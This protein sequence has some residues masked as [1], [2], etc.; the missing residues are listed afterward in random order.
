[1]RTGLGIL[2]W[3]VLAGAASAHEGH[4]RLPL[5][6]GKVSQTPQRGYV[7]ACP[8]RGGPGPGAFR[9][10]EWIGGGTWDPDAK[11]FVEGEVMWPNARI[12]VSVEEGKRVVRANNL[13][14][15]ATGEFPIRP[16]TRAYDYDRNPNHIGEQD[17][18]LS[19]PARPAAASQAGCVPMGMIGFALSGVAIF[20]AFD[21]AQRDA[22]AYEIQDRC[23]G[24]P[25]RTSQ[26]HYH[27]WSPCLAGARPDE[28]VGWML[29]GFPILGP[30]D[31]TGRELTD[32]DLDECHGRVG[33]VRIDGKVVTTFHYRFTREFPYSIGCF[34]GT[35]VQ[36][37]RRGPPPGGGPGFPPPR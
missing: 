25:E 26:Y 19:M 28:P 23:N 11:P 14:R 6:D 31:E 17:I 3:A 16:G 12:T 5:G 9:A 15:H 4:A 24:H 30:V 22:P 18:L 13:P 37:P 27:N 8:M 36:P 21:A 35:P 34:R 7:M 32:A 20:N 1:M 2:A 29:D 10:G 33:P